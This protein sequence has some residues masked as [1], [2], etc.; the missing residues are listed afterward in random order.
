MLPPLDFSRI[1]TDLSTPFG[2]IELGL[3]A[4]CFAGGWAIDRHLRLKRANAGEFVRVGLGGINRMIFP[5]VSL[6]LL[7]LAHA[8]FRLVHP[9]LFLSVALPLAIALALIRLFVYALRGLFGNAS[10]MAASERMISFAIWALV[11]LY[12]LGVLT[13]I[14]TELDAMQITIGKTRVSVLEM[15]KGLVVVMVTIAAAL[16]VSAFIEQKLANTDALDVNLRVVLLAFH[17]GLERR[18]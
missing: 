8:V 4:A 16:W 3:T 10:W 9:P 15:V 12:F 1:T 5:L 7:V 18:R 11:A 2:W 14:G 17:P 6:V 13:Q